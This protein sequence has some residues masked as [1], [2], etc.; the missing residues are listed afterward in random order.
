MSDAPWRARPYRRRGS[1]LSFPRDEGW[2]RLFGEGEG[3]RLT[4]PSMAAMEWVYLNAHVTERGPR[5]RRFVVFVAYFTQ[6]LRFLVVRAWDADDRYLGAWTGTAFGRLRACE[7][8]LDLAFKHDGAREDTWVSTGGFDSKL[9]AFDDA[10]HFSV[11]LSLV[12]TREPYE[13]G[14][15]GY[16][17]FARSGSFYYWSLTRLAVSGSLTLDGSILDVDGI[18]WFDHQ[19]GDFAVTPF[20]IPGFEEYEWISVQLDSGEDLM[21]TTVW[22][23]HGETPSLEA[24]GGVGLVRGD[25][26]WRRVIGPGAITRTRFWRSVEQGAVYAAGWRVQVA[27][28][29]LDLTITPRHAD[30]LTPI[31]DDTA[32]GLAR[33]AMRGLFGP[34]LNHLGAFWEG[35]CRVSGT[36]EGRAVKGVAFAELV[37]RYPEPRVTLSV[38]RE[39]IGFTVLAWRIDGWDPECALRYRVMVEGLDGRVRWVKA[40]LDVAVC[41]LD[42]PSLPR[43]CDLVVR[44][45]AA[46]DDGVVRGDA[47]RVIVLR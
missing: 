36:F 28:W 40:G 34:A 31:V 15:A 24:F 10:G 8:R 37:K 6:W 3:R 46:S 4:N 25:D 14:G 43:G 39:E 22:D 18:G 21:L 29:G 45:V 47:T 33:D 7:D 26:D 9:E 30:Q 17:P 23:R 20:R 27:D 12:N 41:V 11:A 32:P 2:H 13:C 44:V 16:L 38:V 1:A 35:S 19:W 42:D 5:G